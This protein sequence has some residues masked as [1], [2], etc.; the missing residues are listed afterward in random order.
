MILGILAIVVAFHR[1][2]AKLLS[3]FFA[4]FVLKILN[5]LECREVPNVCATIS[6]DKCVR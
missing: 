5:G 4:P 3:G 1:V 6:Q 2:V